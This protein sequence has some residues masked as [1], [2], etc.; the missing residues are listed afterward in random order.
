[1]KYLLGVDAGTTAFKAALFAEDKRLICV[2]QRDYTLLT[3]SENIVE[4]PAEEYWRIFCELIQA[5]LAQSGIC[6]EQIV[7]LAISSQ[8]ETLFCLD[9]AG[10]P[11]GNG[12]VWLDNRAFLEADQLRERFGRQA[13]YEKTGQADM[14]ATWPAAKIL[15]LRK[16]RPQEFARTH[17]FLLLE[18]Y[19]LYRLTGR[20]VGEPNLWAS[21]AMLDI[22]TARWW[23]EMLE[24]L[25][26]DAQR[27]PEILPC[28]SA[29]GCVTARAARE[30]G[31]PPSVL[32]AMGALD[33]T[34]NAIGCGMTRPGV[35]CE[36]TGSCLA[37]SAV[38]DG[39]IPYDPDLPITC[40]NHAVA[41]RYTVLLW[42]QSAGM[43]LKWFAAKF[44][45]DVPE[46]EA[47][48]QRMD[49][50]AERIPL[51]C[52]GLTM[53]PHLTGAAHPEYDT[54]ARGVFSGITLEHGR[55][56]FARAIMEAVACM[57]RRNLESLPIDARRIYCL[58]GG[59]NSKVWLQIKADI[60]Q[61]EMQPVRARES[62]CLGA[63]IL[64]GV[65][66][67]IFE[68]VDWVAEDREKEA[69]FVPDFSLRP[70]ADETYRR[71]I[72]LYGAL[73]QMFRK[74]AR[75]MDAK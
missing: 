16:N 23:P 55:A 48:F 37:V 44:Y 67:G 33:Q 70:M 69:V 26:L 1:M 71:Y 60:A 75:E 74:N 61:R 59:A 13:V 45:P 43:T 32:V 20:Y 29:V 14:T 63:A 18:D 56:H 68:S 54:Y 41:G 52:A 7:A 66:A 39:F 65:G 22:H 28:G 58:G 50:E 40:Q 51:G 12:I 25:G 27:L 19:L 3:P 17:K 42:S 49:A 72:A 34:C 15:W 53:L 30:T 2:E 35:V 8:G 5:L 4:F 10:Q 38:M 21:S 57:L 64:A 47:A 73:Q 24:T 36:T 31:L 46:L 62:A 11:Q 6:A 9:S